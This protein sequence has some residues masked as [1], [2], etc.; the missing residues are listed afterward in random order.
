MIV[1]LT[2]PVGCGKSTELRRLLAAARGAGRPVF[3]YETAWEDPQRRGEG[4]LVLRDLGC[5]G[6][7]P[8]ALGRRGEISADRLLSAAAGALRRMPEAE[9]AVLAIDELGLFEGRASAERQEAFG[10]ALKA[11]LGAASDAFVV[12]QERA[13]GLWRPAL[14]GGEE[15]RLSRA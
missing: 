14:A 9:G 10:A 6:S 11:A 5:P 7:A 15:Q 12:V 8:V 1:V 3:G 2:G 4:A 13:L